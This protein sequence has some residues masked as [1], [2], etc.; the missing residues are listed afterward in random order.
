MT[1]RRADG[2][3]TVFQRLQGE[4]YMVANVLKSLNDRGLLVRANPPVHLR[5][6][7]VQVELL[8]LEAPA[9]TTYTDVRV[10]PRMPVQPAKTYRSKLAQ[11]W[12]VRNRRAL[13]VA[14]FTLAG[15]GTLA[16]L[17]LYAVQVVLDLIST[18]AGYIVGTAVILVG[19]GWVISR[20]S[21]G[22]H[23]HSGV[24]CDGCR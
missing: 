7:L 6:G 13:I 15:L 8:K 23:S 16:A 20:A 22:A 17:A 11:P 12:H 19:L 18:Y 4:P 9:R 1:Q 5:N 21:A 24:H 2:M 14:A 3:V 10:S